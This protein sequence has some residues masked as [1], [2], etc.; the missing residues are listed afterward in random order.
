MEPLPF[1]PLAPGIRTLWVI[2]FKG[3]PE[4]YLKPSFDFF[5][6][7]PFK[8]NEWMSMERQANMQAL[9]LLQQIN[10]A[11]LDIKNQCQNVGMLKNFEDYLKKAQGVFS[12]LEDLDSL[13]KNF[14]DLLKRMSPPPS[15]EGEK[16]EDSPEDGN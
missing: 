8:N 4:V 14:D 15:K 13:M 6:P 16:E 12:E 11:C 7:S 10:R 9:D 1:Q 5:I 3:K 2:R